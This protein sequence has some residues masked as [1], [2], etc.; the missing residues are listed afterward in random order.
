MYKF[1]EQASLLTYHWNTTPCEDVKSISPN[2]K[3][4]LI[5]KKRERFFPRAKNKYNSFSHKS[6][7]EL[8]E[9]LWKKQVEYYCEKYENIIFSITGGADSRVSLAMARG[10]LDKMKFFT[11]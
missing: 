2:F 5:S 6:K 11:Y 4:D 7:L 3:I 8:M 10:H 9:K 1:G